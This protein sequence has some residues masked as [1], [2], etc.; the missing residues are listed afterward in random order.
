VHF[1]VSRAGVRLVLSAAGKSAAARPGRGLSDS[2]YTE[3]PCEEWTHDAAGNL[4][5][6]EASA[7]AGLD[8]EFEYDHRGRL[9]QT[10]VDPGT[11]DEVWLVFAYDVLGRKIHTLRIDFSTVER[12]QYIYDG[13][14]VIEEY[15][16]FEEEPSATYLY[17]DGLDERLQ[18]LSDESWWY[19]DDE[20]GSTSAVGYRD[21]ST[22]VL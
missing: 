10:W 21:G 17:G 13:G 22:L 5:E 4:L 11:M 7:A 19:Y 20:L 12:E 15:P 6:S 8:R 16:N 18:M 2:E 14:N 3:T 9:V 1:A